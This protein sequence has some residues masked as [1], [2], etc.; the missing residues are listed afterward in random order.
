[1][2]VLL[3]LH[4]HICARAALAGGGKSKV[5][6]LIPAD[7]VAAYRARVEKFCRSAFR[8][9]DLPA[10]ARE[11]AA[12]CGGAVRV[13]AGKDGPVVALRVGTGALLAVGFGGNAP[14][15]SN[16]SGGVSCISHSPEFVD[17]ELR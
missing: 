2:I 13:A 15:I 9:D 5:V 3:F 17:I 1:L 11:L 7:V 10:A 16:G 8:P 6:D 12:L 14:V 4:F